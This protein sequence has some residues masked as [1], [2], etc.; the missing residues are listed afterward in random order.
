MFPPL[1]NKMGTMVNLVLKISNSLHK[2]KK[3]SLINKKINL[4]S[5]YIKLLT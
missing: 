3:I 2:N 1:K 5:N 4:Q